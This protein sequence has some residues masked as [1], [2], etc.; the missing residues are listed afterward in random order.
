MTGNRRSDSAIPAIVLA[1]A[2]ATP[3]AASKYKIDNMAALPIGGIA[4]CQYV[5]DALQS[6]GSI[7]NICVVGDVKYKGADLTIKPAGSMLDNIELGMKAC[8]CAADENVLIATSDI[9]FI[10]PEAVDNFVERCG[11]VEAD[12][13][14]PV[15]HKNIME[16]R[17]PGVSRT[18]VRLAEGTFT[19]GNIVITRSW[20]IMENAVLI[21][22]IIDARKNVMRLASIIG[23][24]VLARIIVGQL[25]WPRIVNLA[26]LEKTVSRILKTRVK[27]IQ[28]LH[29]E[30]GA[31]IDDLEQLGLYEQFMMVNS[32]K[33]AAK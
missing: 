25:V 1:G 11:K 18:Y 10:T 12:F 23:F 28:T 24:G 15:V 9:P 19:G 3:E 26:L 2:P 7:G 27:A 8:G 13:Y 31:D 17:F 32:V 20:F 29:P 30:I 4:M 22:E 14:Y 33:S 5:V 6:A 16:S 21:R